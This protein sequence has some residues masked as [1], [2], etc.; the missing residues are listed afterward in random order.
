M[1]HL[2][3]S[4]IVALFLGDVDSVSKFFFLLLPTWLL[5]HVSR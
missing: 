3:F 5:S 1:Q 4:Y 2:F